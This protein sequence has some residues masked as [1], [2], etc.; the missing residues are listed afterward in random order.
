MGQM[1]REGGEKEVCMPHVFRVCGSEQ[2]DRYLIDC[3]VL[4][5]CAIPEEIRAGP[6]EV[7]LLEVPNITSHL[8]HLTCTP[9]PTHTHTH[10]ML[11]K[12]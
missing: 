5:M 9:P 7:T 8:H 3:D 1:N 12:F 10:R 2:R 4:G 6:Y 11:L